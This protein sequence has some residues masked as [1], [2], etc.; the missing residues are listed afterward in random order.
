[1]VMFYHIPNFNWSTDVKEVQNTH[2]NSRVAEL[3]C[4]SWHSN[5]FQSCTRIFMA[6]ESTV[7][8]LF[9]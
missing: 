4:E 9:C 5:A 8:L 2:F 6:T 7:T 1:M 3:K